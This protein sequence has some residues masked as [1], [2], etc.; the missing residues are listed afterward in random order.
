MIDIITNIIGLRGLLIIAA[1]LLFACI[2]L[3]AA[4]DIK[5]ARLDTVK[6]EKQTLSDQV[7]GLGNQ[8]AAQNAAVDQ[9]LANAARQYDKLKAAE[10]K[11]V[12]VRVVTQ[13]RIQYVQAA[14]IPTTCP[15]A[16]A[17]GAAHAIE[18]G[19]RWTQEGV[20]P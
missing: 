8:V 6:A 9:M 20:Q 17:W 10:L 7:Q 11:A 15:E 13:E 16:V 3:T 19:L 12:Q 14:T 4:L 5:C 2:G 18:I 1:A